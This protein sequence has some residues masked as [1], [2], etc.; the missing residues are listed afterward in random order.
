VG[1]SGGSSPGLPG[2]LGFQLA[3][4]FSQNAEH[5]L[6]HGGYL[7]LS[8]TIFGLLRRERRYGRIRGPAL[9]APAPAV[10]GEPAPLS[11][12]PCGL[13]Q[14]RD[15]TLG[16]ALLLRRSLWLVCRPATTQ[17]NGG[18]MPA[19]GRR[20]GQGFSSPSA[21]PESGPNMQDGALGIILPLGAQQVGLQHLRR[22]DSNSA[23]GLRPKRSGQPAP[24]SALDAEV[25]A[26]CRCPVRLAKPAL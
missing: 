11:S 1:A 23:R 2:G 15:A 18:I 17:G 12:Q 14:G 21:G 25:H 9:R 24:G 7:L 26:W 3:G 19:P 13:L 5:D 10:S 6:S 16:V 8:G 22:A 4:A 20:A